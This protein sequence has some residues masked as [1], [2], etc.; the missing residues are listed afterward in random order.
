MIAIES[1]GLDSEGSLASGGRHHASRL[2]LRSSQSF[3]QTSYRLKGIPENLSGAERVSG[4]LRSC[5]LHFLHLSE[6]PRQA[7]PTLWIML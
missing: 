7:V 4:S 5:S 1:Q 2:A 3:S 6:T